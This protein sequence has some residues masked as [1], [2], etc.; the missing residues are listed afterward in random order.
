MSLGKHMEQSSRNTAELAN[1][2]DAL[3]ESL[4]RRVETATAK[5]IHGAVGGVAAV[6]VEFF[7]QFLGFKLPGNH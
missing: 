6:I 1:K 2:L 4:D 7:A 5:Y 3:R